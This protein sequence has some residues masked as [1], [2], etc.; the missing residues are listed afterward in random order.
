MF[1][2]AVFSVVST[3]I[4][5]LMMYGCKGDTE[6]PEIY[7]TYPAEGDS[8]SGIITIT[9]NATDNNEVVK[10]E[11]YIDDSLEYTDTGA[12]YEYSW[13]TSGL[14]IGSTHSI[15]A[16]AYDKEENMGESQIIY[17]TIVSISLEPVGQIVIPNFYAR[18]LAISG[19][20]A[21]LTGD[22]SGGNILRVI[23]LSNPASPAE[24]WSGLPN[25]T[26]IN[27]MLIKDNYLY[28]LYY[29][30]GRIF[31]ITDPS[32]PESVGVFNTGDTLLLMGQG[33]IHGNYLYTGTYTVWSKHYF[34][35]WDITNP[36]FP[37]P[38][39]SYSTGAGNE[40]IDDV[41]IS[42]DGNYAYLAVDGYGLRIIDVSN[43]DSPYEIG[44]LN[45]G[46]GFE[47]ETYGS[48]VFM[49]D[50]VNDI[51]HVIDVSNPNS[52]FE[53]NAFAGGENF[54]TALSYPYFYQGHSYHLYVYDMTDFASS[55]PQLI[56]YT[57][58]LNVNDILV[59]G[60]YIY[61]A[62]GE[63]GLVILKIK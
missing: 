9:V 22:A 36:V 6:N 28:V 45:T 33:D 56:D 57:G 23:N 49:A 11:F 42:D 43:P 5:L 51:I 54:S 35:V 7:I 53:V 26:G 27:P 55:V 20:Y 48:Y 38:I 62:W 4:F 40:F 24:V 61:V 25:L 41:K 44:S 32:Y 10:V 16:R 12:P 37:S 18:C 50:N 46:D 59:S 39:G 30:K 13:N 29:N 21:Y 2:R 3:V 63:D 58:G 8:V 34:V 60:P 31:D 52:P 15:M 17:V 19:S 47:I 14:Q 1:K